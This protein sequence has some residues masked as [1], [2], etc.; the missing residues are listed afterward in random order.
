[1]A[2]NGLFSPLYNGGDESAALEYAIHQQSWMVTIAL[3]INVSAALSRQVLVRYV[4]RL[5]AAVRNRRRNRL[6][7][8][9]RHLAVE[10]SRRVHRSPFNLHCYRYALIICTCVAIF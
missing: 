5:N 3:G 6:V 1:M 10:Q 2:N 9:M 7:A 8:R 4:S